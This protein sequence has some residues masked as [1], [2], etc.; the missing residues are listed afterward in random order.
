MNNTIK[1]N[2]KKQTFPYALGMIS[3]NLEYM[4]VGQ[5]TFALTDSFAMS[6]ATVGLIFLV[7][8]L[9]D[10]FTDIIAGYVIDRFNPKVGKSRV[11]DLL[12]IPLWIA[13][14]LVFSVPNVGN[15]VK[16]IWVF[17]FYNLLQSVLA[18]FMN[19][20]E[21][22][23][24]ERS[25]EEPFRMKAAAFGTMGT[26]LFGY[27]C[28]LTMPILIANYASLPHGWTIISIIYAIPFAIFGIAR[29]FLLPEREIPKKTAVKKEKVTVMQI[30]K[31]LISNKYSFIFGGVMICWAMFNTVTQGSQSFFFKYVY[32]DVKGGTVASALLILNVFYLATVPRIVAKISKVTT[33]KIGL[34]VTAVSCLIRLIMP[35]NLF[36][37]AI[38]NLTAMAGIQTLGCMKA[39][40]NIDCIT[41]GKWKNGEGI[42]AAYSTVNS[43]SDKLGLGIGS[44]L[45][46]FVLEL[47]GFNGALATQSAS[48]VFSIKML[49]T[50]IP[51]VLAVIA[52][53]FFTFFDVEKKLPE[54]KKDL[55]AN[56]K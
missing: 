28:Q 23:R 29:F 26:L 25:V 35:R 49:Y 18:T 37:L 9:F 8:R 44:M 34:S 45:L 12:H 43:L 55:E 19:V 31:A 40:L 11:Y 39:M 6:A 27:I 33:V 30:I 24:L 10:G 14:V 17:I 1:K 46:G 20:A 50:L 53:I 13:L 56:T 3:Y 32:G 7:S 52:I 22:L 16:I 41:Y 2:G 21:P 15:T 36:I 48:A 4:I 38:T 47:G 54:I 5:L 51:A 42:E